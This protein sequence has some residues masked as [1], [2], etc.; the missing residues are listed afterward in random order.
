MPVVGVLAEADVGGEDEI[1]YRVLDGAERGA[2]GSLRVPGG[3]ALGVLCVGDAEEDRGADAGL[4]GGLR[5]GDDQV[6]GKLRDSG[7][8]RDGLL[9]PFSRDGEEGEHEVGRLDARLANDRAEGGGAAQTAGAAL[10]EAH[11]PQ[12]YRRRP[13]PGNETALR[14]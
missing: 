6:D 1:G 3:G 14:A 11:R 4:P 13:A 10:R 9:H 8:G 7:H 5:F 12:R 2:N